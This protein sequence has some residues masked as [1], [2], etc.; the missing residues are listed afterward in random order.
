MTK[1]EHER[2]VDVITRRGVE[3][4]SAADA[5]WLETH[6]SQ[7]AE[8]AEYAALVANTGRLLHSVAVTASPVLV[9]TTQARVRARAEH[10]REQQ[11][12]MV[13][14][15]VSFCIGVLSSTLSAWLWWKFGSWVAEHIGLPTSYVAPGV[16]LFWLLPA[17]V[18]AVL[19]LAFPHPVVEKSAMLWTAEERGGEDR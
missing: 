18:I 3:D 16:L 6:L 2:A 15:A 5:G 7:C 13:L 10:L 19:M 1:H 11:A 8:C 14:I 17:I 9:A 12:R 4:I